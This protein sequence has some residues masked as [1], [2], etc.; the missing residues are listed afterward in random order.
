MERH[1]AKE[2]QRTILN[3]FKEAEEAQRLVR[4]AHTKAQKLREELKSKGYYVS[5]DGTRFIEVAYMRDYN[6][7]KIPAYFD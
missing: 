7:G 5:A 3:C 4:A 6:G 2:V 1:E